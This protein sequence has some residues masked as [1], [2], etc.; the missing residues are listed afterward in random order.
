MS[1]EDSPTES[2]SARGFKRRVSTTL[3]PAII[4]ENLLW[5]TV[6]GL[7]VLI[8]LTAGIAS[9]SY[10]SISN[11][12][13]AQVDR[14]VEATTELH[15][16]A[17]DD[18]FSDQDETVDALAREIALSESDRESVE[19][20]LRKRRLA[21]D[22]VRHYHYV[23]VPSGEILASS[24]ANATGTQLPYDESLLGSEEF[25]FPGRYTNTEG[26][27]VIAIGQRVPMERTALIAT[28]DAEG[29]GPTVEQPIRGAS[30]SVVSPDGTS[31][32]GPP[33][34]EPVPETTADT[35]TIARSQSQILGAEPLPSTD[36]IVIT[37]TPRENAFNVRNAVLR[38]FAAT[39][40]LTFAVLVAATVFVGR[41]VLRD[42]M[43]LARRVQRMEQGDLDV[44][45]ES[46][47]EDEIGQLYAGVAD[48]RDS[49][50]RRISELEAARTESQ[51]AKEEIERQKQALERQNEQL[52]DFAEV[53]S[54][55]LRNPLTVADG[56]VE[57]ARDQCDSPHLDEAAE[58]LE[59]SEA[60]IEDIL[61][62][63][64]EGD[65]ISELATVSVG[66]ITQRSWDN[67]ATAEATLNVEIDRTIRA[68]ASR[69]QQLFENTFRN[70][71]EHAGETVTV[72]VGDLEA[73]S[74]FYVADDGPGI[75]DDPG[76]AVLESGVTTADDGT[77]FGLAI[78]ADIARAH[79]WEV[80][81][82][83]SADGG[84]R[85]EIRGVE[86]VDRT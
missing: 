34:L 78:V 21:D 54:H 52:E 83:E 51:A 61:T 47:R 28:F 57:L 10:I 60:L 81:V 32:M 25:V 1:D 84:A 37:Q 8:C 20:L 40:A 67:V 33:V 5:R 35:V 59:R 4:R 15:T 41:S 11:S 9:V 12:L 72:T 58:A 27:S 65:G 6:L 49:L 50:Q 14:Q 68:D 73:G 38:S 56:H 55:D 42:V 36:L 7:V 71:V 19:D 3:L 22:G 64:R 77:G 74:G 66:T 44:D 16:R 80:A 46:P 43:R 75:P 79:D 2:A 85:I 39:M 13:E 69:L 45:L 53:V 17:Y 76:V 48:M 18:W 31:V 82:A 86:F 24:S 29:A 30:T 70:A 63:A 23:S 62:L 26:R